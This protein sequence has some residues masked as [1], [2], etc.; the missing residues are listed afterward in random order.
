[1]GFV[2]G[3]DYMLESQGW[4]SSASLD[5]LGEAT[6]RDGIEVCYGVAMESNWL[7]R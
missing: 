4:S 7:P 6:G 3:Y 2:M 5:S 1:M